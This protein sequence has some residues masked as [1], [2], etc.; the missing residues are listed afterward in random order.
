MAREPVNLNEVLFEFIVQGNYVK[1]IAVDPVTRTEIAMV[2]DR[3]ASKE[4]L[5]RNAIKK[6]EYVIAKQMDQSKE[7][8]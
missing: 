4:I 8:R 1:V 2:G 5:E 3:R 7:D 6:L